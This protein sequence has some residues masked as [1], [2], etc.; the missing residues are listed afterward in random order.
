[1]QKIASVSIGTAPFTKE[2]AALLG[3]IKAVFLTVSLKLMRS[4]S[5]FTL[6]AIGTISIFNKLF[7]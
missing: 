3:L 7:A 1:M 4:V 5:K 6:I 2:D